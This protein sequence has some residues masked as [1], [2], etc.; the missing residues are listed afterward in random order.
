[1]FCICAMLSGNAAV[2]IMCHSPVD[3]ITNL[4]KKSSISDYNIEATVII[5]IVNL[6][7]DI[8]LTQAHLV[9]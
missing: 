2:S 1:M 6:C 4:E 7:V 3:T 8:S 9:F 5:L